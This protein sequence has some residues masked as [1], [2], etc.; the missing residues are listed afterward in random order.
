MSDA[1]LP[2]P[3]VPT[4]SDV[5]M[6]ICEDQEAR[7]KAYAALGVVDNALELNTAS[8][9]FYAE[10][11]K[12]RDIMFAKVVDAK[13][14][15]T[16][17]LDLIDTAKGVSCQE[18]GRC[19][20]C[21]PDTVRPPRST[22]PHVMYTIPVAPDDDVPVEHTEPF[23]ACP[24]SKYPH[25]RLQM[26]SDDCRCSAFNEPTKQ[27]TIYDRRPKI[28]RDFPRGGF[29]CRYQRFIEN[30]MPLLQDDFS[31]LEFMVWE[32]IPATELLSIFCDRPGLL[33]PHINNL[34]HQADVIE[35][36]MRN[37]FNQGDSCR[38]VLGGTADTCRTSRST[39][40]CTPTEYL[41]PTRRCP[42]TKR[43]SRP[44]SV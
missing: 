21:F 19:C 3:P 20:H 32:L 29:M 38:K 33:S 37:E 15:R 36:L 27:C 16:V 43:S 30:V 40:V 39:S 6:G 2:D 1:V 5:L 8:D 11:R 22:A 28:C 41:S 18:C 23:T 13:C 9:V 7:R 10:M 4:P 25:C 35:Y 12:N 24:G 34:E 31:Q 44:R 17:L 26:R 14:D 42:P